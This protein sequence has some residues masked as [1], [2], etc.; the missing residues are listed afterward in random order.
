MIYTILNG[1]VGFFEYGV[2]LYC[3]FILA[4]Y[5]IISL[6][7]TFEVKK[8]TKRRSVLEHDSL[9]ASPY[10]PGISIIAPAY[11][12]AVTIVDNIR[13]LLSLHYS[14]LTIIIVNDGSKDDTLQ[15]AIDNYDLYKTDEV[16][17]SVID[18]KPIRG[19]YRSRKKAFTKLVVVDK[20]NGGKA[21]AI[22]VGTNVC[23][24]EY[25]ACIDVDCIIDQDA[26]LR[27]VAQPR[28]ARR[29]W[30]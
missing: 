29:P 19:I 8:Y 26:F 11:N 2:F 23:R 13:S 27:L 9:I 4:S 7:S 22:N 17:P 24:S 12:E 10:Q 25:F 16:F 1:M 15:Q 6:I 14:K 28:A 5:V 21:D 30:S 18:T 3:M 20:E